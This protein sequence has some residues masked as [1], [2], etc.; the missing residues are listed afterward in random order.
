MEEEEEEEVYE[1]DPLRGDRVRPSVCLCNDPPESLLIQIVRDDAP[2]GRAC[3]RYYNGAG[4]AVAEFAIDAVRNPDY[5]N[6]FDLN[7]PP[8]PHHRCLG[9]GCRGETVNVYVHWA[10]RGH[11]PGTFSYRRFLC[12]DL[13]CSCCDRTAIWSDED[14]GPTEPDFDSADEVE[15]PPRS[16]PRNLTR[17]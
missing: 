17:L 4:E 5:S 3:V 15:V 1:P 11:F 14:S 13:E 6:V 12:N 16:R 8:P 10:A 2:T 9:N 7:A